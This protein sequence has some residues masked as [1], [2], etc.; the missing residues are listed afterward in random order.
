MYTTIT[1]G[2]HRASANALRDAL[3]VLYPNQFICDIVDIFTDYGPF[4]PYNDYVNMYKL[5]AKYPVTWDVFYHFG[6]TPLGMWL[7]EFLITTFCFDSFTKCLARP[8]GGTGK[9]ADMVI[10]VHP[11]CQ[12]LPLKILSHLDSSGS[13]RMASARTTPFCTVVTDLGGAHPTWFNP[14]YVYGR[15]EKQSCTVLLHFVFL[16]TLYIAIATP[17]SYMLY[18]YASLS[19]IYVGLSRISFRSVPSFAGHVVNGFALT[20]SSLR[21]PLHQQHF[22]LAQSRRMLRPFGCLV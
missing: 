8:I 4:W 3:D 7:N 5:M 22:S 2:G 15:K 11:L 12:D 1:G 19:F 14:G 21:R 17:A 20:P 6:A 10:S 18:S 13:T 16:A 9:R